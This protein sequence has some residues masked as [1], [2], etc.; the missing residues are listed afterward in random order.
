MLTLATEIMGKHYIFL[1]HYMQTDILQPSATSFFSVR[2]LPFYYL[3][4]P[5]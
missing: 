2:F 1:N 5:S 4:I 3:Y